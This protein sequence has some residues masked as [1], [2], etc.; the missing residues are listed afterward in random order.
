MDKEQLITVEEF[1]QT[2]LSRRG[3]PVTHSYIYRMIR[4]Y[5]GKIPGKVRLSLPFKYKE[6]GKGIMIVKQ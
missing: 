4:E 2:Y 5:E 3:Y 1:R 6:V